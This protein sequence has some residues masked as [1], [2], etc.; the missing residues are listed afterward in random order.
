M[1]DQFRHHQPMVSLMT[2]NYLRRRIG[3]VM[4]LLILVLIFAV[5]NAALIEIQLLR[6]IVDVRRSVLIAVVLFIG[7][8]MGWSARTIYRILKGVPRQSD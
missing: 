1:A 3:L 4:V 6:W 5:Q 8:V 2:T 7:F